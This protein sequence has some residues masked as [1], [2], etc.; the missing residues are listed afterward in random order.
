MSSADPIPRDAYTLLADLVTTTAGLPVTDDHRIACLLCYLDLQ[1]RLC[2]APSSAGFLGDLAAAGFPSDATPGPVTDAF[3]AAV[4][5]HGST[6][7]SAADG[8]R[9]LA[10][11]ADAMERD[12]T[13][14]PRDY[15]DAILGAPASVS[16]DPQPDSA[17]S[18]KA[19][20]RRRTW[21]D[22]TPMPRLG[23]RE[24]FME[25][26]KVPRHARTSR[27]E[28]RVPRGRAV[29]EVESTAPWD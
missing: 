27:K 29:D 19:R 24:L 12:H 22:V 1:N 15:C 2:W 26:V 3:L 7:A 8:L 20:K 9:L 13:I 28:A 11:L 18:S 10:D 6:L 4:A 25:A 17:P 16:V 21:A 14:L 5:G 23:R